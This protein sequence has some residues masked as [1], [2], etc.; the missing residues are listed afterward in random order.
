[1]RFET[2]IFSRLLRQF[3]CGNPFCPPLSI[4]C[5]HRIV[6]FENLFLRICGPFSAQLYRIGS[7]MLFRTGTQMLFHT[8]FGAPKHVI[9]L[10]AEVASGILFSIDQ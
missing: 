6:P 9:A 5:H 8:D 7:Q 2:Q 1:M 3:L 10:S 4:T